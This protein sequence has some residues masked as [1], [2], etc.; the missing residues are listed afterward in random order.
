[1]NLCN[2][3]Y[4]FCSVRVQIRSCFCDGRILVVAFHGCPSEVIWHSKRNKLNVATVGGKYF[5][6]VARLIS[7]M[8]REN[9][10][11]RKKYFAAIL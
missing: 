2:F 3:F 7:E 5:E 10:P 11:E 4:P 6:G 1:M 8:T 9:H